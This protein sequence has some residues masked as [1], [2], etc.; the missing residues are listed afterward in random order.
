[1]QPSAELQLNMFSH[2]FKANSVEPETSVL[3]NLQG[4]EVHRN[5]HFRDDPLVQK[6]G[7]GPFFLGWHEIR[8]II[9]DSLPAGVVQF[10]SQ[11]SAVQI[12]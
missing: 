8:Q 10:S 1:M 3:Y 2:R 4:N 5:M 7:K 6:Y 11:V 12:E 9:F